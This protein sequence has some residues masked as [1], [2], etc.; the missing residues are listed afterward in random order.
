MDRLHERGLIFNAVFLRHEL[1]AQTWS[2]G[3]VIG[4]SLRGTWGEANHFHGLA[5]GSARDRG[6]FWIGTGQG[7]VS[8]VLLAE[9]PI[10]TMSLAVLD[11]AQRGPEEGVSIYLSTD[12]SGWVPVETLKTVLRS[13]GLVAAAFD[14][15][16]AGETMAWRVAQQ[17]PGIERLTPN[18]GKDWNEVLVNPEGGGDGWQQSRS[19]LG[20][21]WRWHW[22]A[23]ALGRPE[24]YLSRITEVAREV[25]KGQSLSEKAIAA[26]QRDLGS[27][28]RA[29]VKKTVDVEM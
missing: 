24:G 21:L 9:S 12:G 4:A 14:A 15:D 6:W 22:A 1:Q 16:V 3:E 7:P 10:D 11:R 19:E 17:V 2:R 25:A 13:G 23:V 26:M 5:P 28:P 18:Q 27:R 20:Q 29:V 8:R